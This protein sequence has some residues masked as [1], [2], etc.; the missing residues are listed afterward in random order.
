MA[1]K[2]HPD[3]HHHL[4]GLMAK[5]GQELQ[6]PMAG[7]AQLHKHAIAEGALGTKV[8]EL[9]ALGIAIAVRCDGCITYHVHDALRAGASR[10]EVLETIG[11]AVLM[12]GGPGAIYGTE[13]FEALE[14][15]EAAAVR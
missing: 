9:I 12:A 13:A 1:E 14:Q 2:N 15:F 6:G 5:L 8:K 10:Q 4:Q 3:Y 7:F 11:V